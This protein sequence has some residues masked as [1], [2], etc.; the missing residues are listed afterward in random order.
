MNILELKDVKI[1]NSLSFKTENITFSVKKGENICVV[2]PSGCGKTTILRSI[3]GFVNI[4]D[5]EIN[6]NANLISTSTFHVPP[7]NRRIGMVFQEPSLF[8]HL[9]IIQNIQ[10]GLLKY[11][12]NDTEQDKLNYIDELTEEKCYKIIEYQ[13]SY[14]AKKKSYKK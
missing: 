5:G 6:Y 11:D 14:K 12:K 9:T 4:V 13:K 1:V 8:P 3:A 7:E 2:G 10:A